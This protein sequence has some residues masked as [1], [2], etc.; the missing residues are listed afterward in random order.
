MNIVS[1]QVIK[2]MI[3]ADGRRTLNTNAPTCVSGSAGKQQPRPRHQADLKFVAT[4]VQVILNLN[5]PV[6]I[7]Q[8]LSQSR[9]L[10]ESIL[11]IPPHRVFRPI[12]FIL[13][14][15]ALNPVNPALFTSQSL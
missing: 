12:L 9:L 8:N 11:P 10:L 14:C 4:C 7:I 1:G 2:L 5:Q 6:T 3:Q 15:E 13:P